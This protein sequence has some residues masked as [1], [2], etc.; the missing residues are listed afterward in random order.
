MQERQRKRRNKR[1]SALVKHSHCCISHSLLAQTPSVQSRCPAEDVS[2]SCPTLRCRTFEACHC[3]CSLLSDF[4]LRDVEVWVTSTMSSATC[5]T[6]I[7]IT[8]VS[9]T[10]E[11]SR[12]CLQR[13]FLGPVSEG[14]D[15]LVLWSVPRR[16]SD[17]PAISSTIC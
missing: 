7:E 11:E 14:L 4:A 6:N 2:V 17:P 5:G 15:T 9:V 3:L 8:R 12:Q 16:Q 1:R 13:L 10:T